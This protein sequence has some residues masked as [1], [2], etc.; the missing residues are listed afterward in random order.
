MVTRTLTKTPFGFRLAYSLDGENFW[1]E[2][3]TP[4]HQG[5]PFNRKPPPSIVA[6]WANRIWGWIGASRAA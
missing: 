2:Y 4:P 3:V 5:S 6:S 1:I